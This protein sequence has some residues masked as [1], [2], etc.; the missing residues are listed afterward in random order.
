MDLRRTKSRARTNVR[1][2]LLKE[3]QAVKS[4]R[5]DPN[6]KTQIKRRMD[7]AERER[8]STKGFAIPYDVGRE[9]S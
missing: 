6:I 4:T 1:M 7:D 2:V 5:V 8:D 3:S 9:N